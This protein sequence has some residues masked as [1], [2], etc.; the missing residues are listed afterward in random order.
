MCGLAGELLGDFTATHFS[1]PCCPERFSQL[2]SKLK[3]V[4]VLREPKARSESRFTEQQQM[5]EEM[6][7]IA[8]S[9]SCQANRYLPANIPFFQEVRNLWCNAFSN[10]I[11]WSNYPVYLHN[12]LKFFDKD[13]LL[14]IYTEQIDRDP[15]PVL[16]S[17]E[18]FLGIEPFEYPEDVL[19]HA[20]FNSGR[21]GYGWKDEC[22]E[23]T[24]KTVLKNNAHPDFHPEVDPYFDDVVRGVLD[25]AGE[26]KV[27]LP[28]M[29]WLAG[30]RME[31]LGLTEADYRSMQKRQMD[32]QRSVT[33]QEMLSQLH[34]V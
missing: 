15:L 13:Q 17:V 4:A 3:L 29:S 18:E 14:I 12:W 31:R 22:T 32:S 25:L 20:H 23:T 8:K 2:D 11:G 7:W 34:L 24:H 1:C 28:P 5:K 21:C 6:M 19:G 16:R 9:K 10:I 26:G 27:T 30:G 33:R